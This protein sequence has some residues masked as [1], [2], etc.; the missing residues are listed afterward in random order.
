MKKVVVPIKTFH[1]LHIIPNSTCQLSILW[2]LLVSHS[3]SFRHLK[4]N[5]SVCIHL[6]SC[7]DGRWPKT[8]DI[9]KRSTESGEENAWCASK[10]G[11]WSHLLGSW[12]WWLGTA[13]MVTV[14]ISGGL[15]GFQ[16]WVMVK[17]GISDVTLSSTSQFH[18]VTPTRVKMR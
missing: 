9:D 2:I 5:P 6:Y 10:S 4:K 17:S 12:C 14:R 1:C 8:I 15:W 3:L 18:C 11:W 13:H 7:N 16:R